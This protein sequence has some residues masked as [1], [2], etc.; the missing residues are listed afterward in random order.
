MKVN[1]LKL[2]ALYVGLA[3]CAQ[4]VFAQSQPSGPAQDQQSQQNKP[5][6]KQSS[7]PPGISVSKLKGT[8]VKSNDGQ[9]LGKLEDVIID[10]QTGKVTYAV[11]GKGG[12]LSLGEKRVPIPWQAVSIDQQKHLTVK[13]DQKKMQS[14]PTVSSDQNYA[15]LDNPDFVVIIDEFYQVPPEAMGAPGQDSDQG[16]GS[17]SSQQQ[18]NP[19]SDKDTQQP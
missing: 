18:D 9:N 13:V 10:P 1:R 6:A 16:T 7:N 12:V 19:D 2:T 15:A 3:F 17:G 14:A 8:D 11:V 5:G 4:V